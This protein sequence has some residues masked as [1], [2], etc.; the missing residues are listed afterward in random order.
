MFGI[1]N[2][3]KYNCADVDRHRRENKR[4]TEETQGERYSAT[5]VPIKGD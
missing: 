5:S 1:L 4:K 2:K 3:K